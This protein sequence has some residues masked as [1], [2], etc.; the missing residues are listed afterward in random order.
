MSEITE[1]NKDLDTKAK[2]TESIDK[3]IIKIS[4]DIETDKYMDNRAASEAVALLTMAKLF[5]K[6]CS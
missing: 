1:S 2:I 5:N 6:L 3:A 4:N